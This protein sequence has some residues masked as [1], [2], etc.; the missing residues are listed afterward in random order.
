MPEAGGFSVGTFLAGG[1]ISWAEGTEGAGG[2]L[3][4]ISDGDEVDSDG[5]ASACSRASSS[6]AVPVLSDTFEASKLKEGTFVLGF[7]G[8][9][10][11]VISSAENDDRPASSPLD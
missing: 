9:A 8:C 1:G 7:T 11:G 10:L 3:G 5:T 4:L 6:P 2:T